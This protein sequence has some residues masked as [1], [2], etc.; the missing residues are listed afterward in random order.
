MSGKIKISFMIVIWSIVTLQMYINYRQNERRTVSAFSVVDDNVTEETVRG[1]GYFETME[2]GDTTKKKMLERLA[3]K[4][5]ITD[6]YTMSEGCGDGYR[7]MML[8]KRGKHAVTILQIVSILDETDKNAVP[9]QYISIE[10]NTAATTTKAV[11]LYNKVKELF[12]E[13]GKQSQVSLEI[14]AQ[15]KG[16]FVS[17]KGRGIY[18]EIFRQVKAR[19]VDEVMENGICTVY[20]YTKAFD[21]HLMLNKN[22][23]NVQVVLS[24]DENDD[25][26]YIKIGMPIVNSSY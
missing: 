8:T 23:V 20:G 9:G 21:N 15:K 24:Y 13:I 25:V 12:A 5:G 18:E 3:G 11:N 7:K 22:K 14:N 17:L 10:I 4:L 1:Y 26:T 16:D 19:K 2:L 6:G